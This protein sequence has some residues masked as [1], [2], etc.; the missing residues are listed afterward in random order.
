MNK[1]LHDIDDL[2][3]SSLDGYEE[4]PTAGLKEKL[5]ASLDKKDAESYKKRLIGWKRTTLLLLLLLTG[6][7]IYESGILKNTSARSD[8]GTDNKQLKETSQEYKETPKNNKRINNSNTDNPEPYNNEGIKNNIDKNIYNNENKATRNDNSLTQKKKEITPPVVNNNKNKTG[9]KK[10]FS[11]NKITQEKIN[12]EKEPN[13]SFVKIQKT[14]I[15][16]IQ[17]NP[18]R[19]PAFRK[20][21]YLFPKGKIYAGELQKETG[22]AKMISGLLIRINQL[23]ATN[24]SLLKNSIVKNSKEKSGKFFSPFS[25]LSAFAS[26]ENAGYRLDSDAPVNIS[27]IKHSE[28]PE[29]S[30]SLGVLF[31][32]QLKKHLGLQ[33]GLIY[34]QTDI[35]ISPQK[36]FAL[37]DPGGDISFKYITSS[38]YAYIKPG[39][40]TPLAIGDSIITTEGKHSLKTISVP[41]VIKYSVQ[42]NKTTFTPG[43]GIEANF[44]TSAKVE[45]EFKSPTNPEIIFINKLQGAK[46]FYVSVV[47][48]AEMRYKLNNKLSVSIRPAIR[49]AISPIT[50]N[51]VVETFP[52]SAGVG[53]GL[54]W[55]F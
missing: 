26:Y 32:R 37:Q 22:A 11:E 47:A 53:V 9:F 50:E 35:G 5:D 15:P 43:A 29:P 49:L 52:R 38:G 24:D 7:I 13:N 16:G 48:D 8:E 2:F 18:E 12:Q 21:I 31:T 30:F 4:I 1:D 27:N 28:I 23:L 40:G 36:L 45:T 55:K 17:Q 3:R 44:L 33:T 10:G 6:F 34:S 20:T 39:L 51:N 14:K 41:L 42:K 19:I 54:S 46:P 25:M